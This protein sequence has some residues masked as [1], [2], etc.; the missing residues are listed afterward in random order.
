MFQISFQRLMYTC[1]YR[2]Y[3][4]THSVWPAR[5]KTQIAAKVLGALM[6]GSSSTLLQLQSSR[7]QH[8]ELLRRWCSRWKCNSK[9]ASWSQ[10]CRANGAGELWAS[11]CCH[12]WKSE[13]T[14]QSTC[15][16]TLACAVSFWFSVYI[17]PW[18]SDRCTTLV[19]HRW[20]HQQAGTQDTV[21]ILQ[22]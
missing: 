7:T 10:G 18:V 9:N 8:A 16:S 3:L 20:G 22:R 14:S 17:W 12:Q 1:H 4:T 6:M 21:T 13:A 19:Q 15:W 11:C 2:M 5:F